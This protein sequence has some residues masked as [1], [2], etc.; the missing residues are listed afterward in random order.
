M[1][2]SLRGHF[3]GICILTNKPRNCPT[4]SW[5]VAKEDPS[6]CGSFAETSSIHG[7]SNKSG[8]SVL[9][10]VWELTEDGGGFL[11]LAVSWEIRKK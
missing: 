4:F 2:A 8:N 7:G 3:K 9:E 6:C 5:V 10:R 11:Q 1:S